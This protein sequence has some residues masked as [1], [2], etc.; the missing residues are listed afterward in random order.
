MA[1]T[2]VVAILAALAAADPALAQVAAGGVPRTFWQGLQSGLGNP[3]IGLVHLAAAI[4]AGCLAAA[5]PKGA[6]PVIVYVFATLIGAGA[7]IGE[8]TVANAEVFVALSVVALGL[9]IFRKNP[10][11]R[12]ITF[13]LFAGVGLL[14]GYL[15][16]AA[17]AAAQREPILGYLIGLVA[18]QIAVG[19]AVMFGLRALASRAQLQLLAMRV[20][21]AFAVGA[22]AAMLLQRYAGT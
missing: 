10:L 15:M 5:Y 17:I 4:A 18:I 19:L 16:G 9:L 3:V 8:R 11:R 12:D 13:A 20:I 14:N 7:H 1:R 6:T 22:G 2:I 21:G